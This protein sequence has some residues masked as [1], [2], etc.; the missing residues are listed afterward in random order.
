MQDQDRIQPKKADENN[1][2]SPYAFFP[3]SAKPSSASKSVVVNEGAKLQQQMEQRFENMRLNVTCPISGEVMIDPVIVAETGQTYEREKIQEWFKK[4]DKD[5][6]TNVTVK[7]RELLVPN[8]ALREF[9][10]AARARSNQPVVASLTK[11]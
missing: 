9:C 4:S 1:N 8:V 2:N 3:N 11:N 7:N 10:D 5:P 6:V